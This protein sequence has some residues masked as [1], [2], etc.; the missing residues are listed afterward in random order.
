M[1]LI[2]GIVSQL[3]QLSIHPQFLA[4]V[5]EERLAD[6]DLVVLNNS[7][8][9]REKKIFLTSKSD[10]HLVL[11]VENGV[12]NLNEI[13][14]TILNENEQ[15]KD[16][17]R[18]PNKKTEELELLSLEDALADQFQNIGALVFILIGSR[19]PMAQS[20]DVQTGEIKRV[21]FDSSQEGTVISNEE[22]RVRELFNPELR[23][24]VN[25]LLSADGDTP[26]EGV[27][28]QIMVGI[29]KL[30]KDVYDIVKFPSGDKG[31]EPNILDEFI[32][33]LDSQIAKYSENIQVI[34]SPLDYSSVAYN[35]LLR[36]AY[37]FCDDALDLYY[38]ILNL[39]DLK[40]IVHWGTIF[41]H[42]QIKSILARMLNVSTKPQILEDYVKKIKDARNRIAHRMAPFLHTLEIELPEASI[43]SPRLRIFT[44]FGG[45]KNDNEFNFEDKEIVDL[46]MHFKRTNEEAVT[47]DFLQENMVFMQAV[48]ELFVSTNEFLKLLYGQTKNG[49]EE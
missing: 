6:G 14:I 17:R 23:S 7:F 30:R 16:F 39:C 12:L 36:I 5:N 42:Y 49:A 1:S 11:P 44:P 27:L 35:E 34:P 37:L 24:E 43:R 48:R 40:P 3:R 8:I 47:L 32:S 20:V 28:D 13:H 25:T 26:S 38:L 10:K 4:E 22:L 21:V 45:A 19:T 9:K 18:V 46:L 33:A 31:T 15:N 2:E 41:H 29:N